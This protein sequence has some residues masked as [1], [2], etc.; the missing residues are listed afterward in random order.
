MRRF[1]IA[2]IAGLC[3][4]LVAGASTALAGGPTKIPLPAP[5]HQVLVGSCTFPVVNDV[6]VNDEFGIF[7]D[8]YFIVAGRLV[9]R[10]THGSVSLVENIS[11]PAKVVP[12]SD[13]TVTVY[14]KGT[15][16]IPSPGHL[17]LATG[18]SVVEVAADGTQILVSTRGIV[19]DLCGALS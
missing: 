4:A 13:G 7:F 18:N 2:A 14:G 11:G 16:L 9:V 12:H 1:P 10:L 6:L 19:Q 17:W 8:T 15:G 5:S 3:C